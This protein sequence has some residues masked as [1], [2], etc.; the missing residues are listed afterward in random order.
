MNE[1]FFDI[2]ELERL[3]DFAKKNEIKTPLLCKKH[4]IVELDKR[5]PE[6][7]LPNGVVLATCPLCYEE[8]KHET[9]E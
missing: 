5:L 2:N 6:M 1:E 4:G 7:T 8:E 3:R 9:E